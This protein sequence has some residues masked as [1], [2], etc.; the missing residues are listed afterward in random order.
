MSTSYVTTLLSV[1][2]VEVQRVMNS[3]Q[4]VYRIR[5]KLYFEIFITD[6]LDRRSGNRVEMEYIIW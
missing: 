1:G 3:K 6:Y 5:Y 2:N 4:R